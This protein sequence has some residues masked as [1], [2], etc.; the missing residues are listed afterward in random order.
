MIL[1]Q[2]ISFFLIYCKFIT[3]IWEGVTPVLS[4]I[5]FYH[6]AR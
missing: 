6:A 3:F 1:N 4:T 2:L 5:V